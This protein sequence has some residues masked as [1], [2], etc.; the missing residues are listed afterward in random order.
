MHTRQYGWIQTELVFTLAKNAIKPNS[1]EIIPLQTTRKENNW[2]TERT[3]ARAAVTLETERIKLSNPWC[4]WWWQFQPSRV[5]QS[6]V[7]ATEATL[8]T[9]SNEIHSATYFNLRNLY[10]RQ[11][12]AVPSCVE[13]APILVQNITRH[14]SWA[15]WKF[16][17]IASVIF[18]LSLRAYI[19]SS[20]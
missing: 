12:S 14:Y 18:S 19:D 16:I 10:T 15:R 13:P 8:P 11:D 2:K 7:S 1:L 6:A 4:L 17:S 5:L 20:P 3:L 9:R